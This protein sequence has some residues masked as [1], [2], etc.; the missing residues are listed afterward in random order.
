MS[1]TLTFDDKEELIVRKLNYKTKMWSKTDYPFTED[2]FQKQLDWLLSHGF[3]RI[4]FTHLSDKKFRHEP[5]K[6]LFLFT[7]VKKIESVLDENITLKKHVL[8]DDNVNFHFSDL[9][10]EGQSEFY[11]FHH[12]QI[13]RTEKMENI[14]F[15]SFFSLFENLVDYALNVQKIID[16]PSLL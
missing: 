7:F 4:A 11:Q 5:Q 14:Q 16:V 13:S 8:D 6:Y 1:K 2:D 3:Q 10:L 9:F 12:R 15:D